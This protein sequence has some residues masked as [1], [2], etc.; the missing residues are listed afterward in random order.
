M[1]VL[2]VVNV[3]R[4]VS[5]LPWAVQYF[6]LIGISVACF[7]MSL[8]GYVFG[9][10]AGSGSFARLALIGALACGLVAPVALL[11]DLHQPGRFWRFYA[12]PNL[13]SW[14]A[15]GSFF[16]PAY[17]G[18]LLAYAWSVLRPD[19]AAVG[20]APGAMAALYRV[21][22]CGDRPSPRLVR[23]L[24]AWTAVF[25]VLMLLYTGMEVMVVRARPLWNTPFLPLQFAATAFVGAGG[26]VLL[27]Q[28]VLRIPDA[29]AEHTAGRWMLVALLATVV[30]GTAWFL[31]GAFGLDRSHSQALASVSHHEA[32][33]FTALWLGAA[34]LLPIA[35]L[36]FRPIGLGWLVGLLGLHVAWMLR[37]TVFIGGQ[38]IPKT[39]AGLYAYHLPLGHD[40]LLGIAGT[41]GLWLFV[42]IV[43]TTLIP[44]PPAPSSHAPSAL[45]PAA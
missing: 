23:V 43:L 2:E 38:T 29:R 6:F 39:G 41:L 44:A 24:A 14:M 3:S 35:L 27:L 21:I 25:A 32:W 9:R 15:W 31:T 4:E 22:A 19:F 16:I 36:W 28:T 34:T 18:G 10:N 40:G 12:H 17:V 26:L 11:A 33:K 5:W 1:S 45:R 20:R 37:W 42:A 7:V 13:S 30:L 8:P